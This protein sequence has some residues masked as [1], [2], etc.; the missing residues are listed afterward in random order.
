MDSGW[1]R[2]QLLLW[3]LVGLGML[4]LVAARRAPSSLPDYGTVP[5]FALVNQEGRAFT[6]VDLEGTV[7]IADFIFTSCAGQCLLM[8]DQLRA[9]QR[10]YADAADLRFISFSVHPAHDTPERLSAY[11]ARHGA[12]ARWQLLTGERAALYALCQQGFRLAVGEDAA[13]ARE[14]IVHSVRLVLVDRAGRIRGYYEATDAQAMGRLRRDAR[15]LLEG[16][17]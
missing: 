15:Q 12:D 6:R 16:P 3:G 14:P 9:L 7:W 4:G 5:S 17:G 1:V 10:T 13:S 8:S 2:R 11:A